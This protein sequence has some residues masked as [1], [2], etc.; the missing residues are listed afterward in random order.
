MITRPRYRPRNRIAPDTVENRSRSMT[1]AMVGGSSDGKEKR[2][3]KK[4]GY[5]LDK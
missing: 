2:Q 4:N 3:E 1:L 5:S